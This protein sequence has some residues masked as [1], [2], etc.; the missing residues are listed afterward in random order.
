MIYNPSFIL[1]ILSPEKNIVKLRIVIEMFNNLDI[2]LMMKQ[3]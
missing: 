1:G 3:N 2:A